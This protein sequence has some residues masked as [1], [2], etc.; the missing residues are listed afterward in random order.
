MSNN[1]YKATIYQKINGVVK[2]VFAKTSVD[3]VVSEDGTT[4]IANIIGAAGGIAT[5]DAN[6][7]LT[8]S[9]LPSTVVNTSSL[10]VA[11]GV[12]TLDSNSKLTASQ[13]PS[14]VVNTSSLGVANGVATLDSTGKIPSN[15]LPSV[16]GNVEWQTLS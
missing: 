12:A 13:L 8:P 14:T 1:A 16:G 9:Q 4:T 5:L 7:Q 6:S 2:P 3:Q 11:N 15:Q 10:G